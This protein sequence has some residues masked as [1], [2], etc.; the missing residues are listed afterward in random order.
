MLANAATRAGAAR[1]T[2]AGG[3]DGCMDGRGGRGPRGGLRDAR[4]WRAHGR[5]GLLAAAAG[6]LHPDRSRV[7][8]VLLG[9]ESCDLVPVVL[10]PQ[11]PELP[12]L[13]PRLFD[14][15]RRGGRGNNRRG[16][17]LQGAHVVVVGRVRAAAEHG[18]QAPA[19]RI[20]RAAAAAGTAA[21]P[22]ATS[23]ARDGRRRGRGAATRARHETVLAVPRRRGRGKRRRGRHGA[24]AAADLEPQVKMVAPLDAPR[25][26]VAVHDGAICVHL[27]E[28]EAPAAPRPTQVEVRED[29]RALPH[30]AKEATEVAL[31]LRG[32]VRLEHDNV[33][34]LQRLHLEE[35]PAG[36]MQHAVPRAV[37]KVAR[38]ARGG[39]RRR[40]GW[41]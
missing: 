3:G 33:R 37:P 5:R 41:G 2:P 17:V 23:A 40:G 6:R 21:P 39:R 19:R 32:N 34:Q 36:Q 9:I 35:V 14:H 18:Q 7:G 1:R 26:G 13:L 22:P 38:A 12:L 31:Q 15:L 20:I 11:P 28:G 10:L 27:A 16:L 8:R 4:L 25:R 24:V 29:A 30:G